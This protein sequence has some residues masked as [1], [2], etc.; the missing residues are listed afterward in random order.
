MAICISLSCCIPIFAYNDENYESAGLN[1]LQEQ[2]YLKDINFESITTDCSINLYGLEDN[3]IAKMLVVNRDGIFDYVIL[4]FLTDRIDEYGFDQYD[5]IQLFSSKEKV[6]YA[7][8]MNYAYYDENNILRGIYG[9]EIDEE[10]FLQSLDIFVNIASSIPHSSKDGYGGFSSWTDVR[11]ANYNRPTSS[12]Y[13][14]TVTNN[15]WSYLYGI[16]IN[17]THS[18]LTFSN[19]TDLNNVYNTTY[20]KSVSGTCAPTAITNMFIYYNY[21]GFSNALYHNN[22]NETF[23]KVIQKTDW[24]NWTDSNWWSKTQKGLKDMAT[25]LG[26]DYSIKVYSNASWNN[27]TTCIK[28]DDIPLFTY[29]GVETT[30][31]NYFAHAVVTVGYEEFTHSYT[32]TENYWLF[33]WRTKTVEHNDTYRYLRVIDGWGSSNDS[34]YVD[35]NGYFTTIKAIGFVLE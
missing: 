9:D 32:T 7:G 2:Y 6:L 34:R 23:A 27:F 29:L 35:F 26:Y 12:G 1:F 21:C 20:G 24:T 18:G 15:D 11:S 19:Q 28:S 17:G 14:G 8:L 22:V 30:G 25:L 10:S 4:D 5:F 31:G 33:G 16:N 13:G 3:I